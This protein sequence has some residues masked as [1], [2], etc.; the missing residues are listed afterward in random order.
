MPY[1][2]FVTSGTLEFNWVSVFAIVIFNFCFFVF[3]SS[4]TLLVK[5]KLAKWG[6]LNLMTTQAHYGDTAKIM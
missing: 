1:K 3:F 2:E 5:R 4:K 6:K